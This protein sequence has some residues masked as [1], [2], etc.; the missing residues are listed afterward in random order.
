MI[1][2]QQKSEEGQ[3]KRQ[4][5]SSKHTGESALSYD[6]RPTYRIPGFQTLIS[7][8]VSAETLDELKFY[9]KSFLEMSSL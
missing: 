7:D 1:I 8:T 3:M 2:A 4:V 6:I 5:G 9:L